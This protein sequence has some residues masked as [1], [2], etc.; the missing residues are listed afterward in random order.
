MYGET[1]LFPEERGQWVSGDDE[2]VEWQEYFELPDDP[3]RLRLEGYNEDDMYEHSF[4]VRFAALP[5]RI[6]APWLGVAR[7]VELF[8]RLIGLRR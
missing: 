3:T 6:A 7:F 5:K 8:S 4:Y 2:T 1:Q